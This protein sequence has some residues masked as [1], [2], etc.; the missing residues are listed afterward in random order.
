[1]YLVK[2]SYQVGMKMAKICLLKKFQIKT[3]P[4]NAIYNILKHKVV[5]IK[6]AAISNI[7][8]FSATLRPV[9]PYLC[10]ISNAFA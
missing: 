4:D 7:I 1:M 5:L 2:A 6:C 3:N 8:I 9:L 10:I